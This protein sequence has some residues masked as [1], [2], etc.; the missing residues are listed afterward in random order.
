MHC[1]AG[2]QLPR[3]QSAH[4]QSGG[5]FNNHEPNAQQPNHWQ[6][7]GRTG[8]QR[9]LIAE[10]KNWMESIDKLESADKF[11]EFSRR[12]R[13]ACNERYPRFRAWEEWLDLLEHLPSEGEVAYWASMGD[14]AEAEL[15]G[16]DVWS[17]LALK[18]GAGSLG[19]IIDR[20]SLEP[21][22]GPLASLHRAS[23]AWIL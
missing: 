8:M 9:K 18:V 19:G 5:L 11:P 10:E 4:H 22:A 13:V 23:R 1:P 15:L 2:V 14:H 21:F 16:R 6:G 12:I 3:D 17:I 20:M 7:N